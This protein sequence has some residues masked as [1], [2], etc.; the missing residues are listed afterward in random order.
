MFVGISVGSVLARLCSTLMSAP[1]YA[2][3]G[4]RILSPL[5]IP[6]VVVIA[7]TCVPTSRRHREFRQ[8]PSRRPGEAQEQRD[9]AAGRGALPMARDGRLRR[10]HRQ[11]G[12]LLSTTIT[13]YLTTFLTDVNHMNKTQA[14]NVTI[15]SNVILIVTICPEPGPVFEMFGL[16]KSRR[17]P[18]G[19]SPSSRFPRWPSL[20]TGS[21]GERWEAW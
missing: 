15:A 8:I 7:S 12:A 3:Y 14:Y 2:T 17:A 19:S 4:W 13:A 21:R 11:L 20:R 6:M 10:G 5:A 18:P 1:A 9:A 16:R